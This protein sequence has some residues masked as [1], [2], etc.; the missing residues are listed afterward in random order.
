LAAVKKTSA[1]LEYIFLDEIEVKYILMY[2]LKVPRVQNKVK[3]GTLTVEFRD[4]E[5]DADEVLDTS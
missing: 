4:N 3:R 2:C 5:V 1:K